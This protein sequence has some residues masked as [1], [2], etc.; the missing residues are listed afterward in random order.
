[1][2]LL[3]EV[4][5]QG[6]VDGQNVLKVEACEAA[7]AGIDISDHKA[8]RNDERIFNNRVC[9]IRK[10]SVKFDRAK[11][12]IGA[13]RRDKEFC[14][15]LDMQDDGV[16]RIINCKPLKDASSINYLFSQAKFY[17]ESFLRDETFL[18][19]IRAHIEQSPSPIKDKYLAYISRRSRT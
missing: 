13:G 7:Y 18:A 19:E 6:P 1:M 3:I 15:I 12:R 10:T 5:V 8:K 14:D 16:V 2:A 17:C 9:E 11:L 4:I